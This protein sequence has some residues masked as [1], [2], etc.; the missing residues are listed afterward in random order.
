MSDAD[1][2]R[3]TPPTRAC[4]AASSRTLPPTLRLF[5]SRATAASATVRPYF[6][7]RSGSTAFH[8]RMCPPNELDLADARNGLEQ[9]ARSN[10]GPSEARSGAP[11]WPPRP[12]LR[13]RGPRACI[14]GRFRPWPE[15]GPMAGFQSLGERAPGLRSTAPGRAWRGEIDVDALEDDRDHRKPEL[16]N[17]A[18]PGSGGAGL[19]GLFR[20]ERSRIFRLPTE[21][22]P[23]PRTR[24]RPG[25]W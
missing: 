3:P 17:G 15:T 10:P 20:P 8:R 25:C 11:P 9:G 13:G 24:L 19:E 16:G 12:P 7:R 2:S 18:E 6:R 1:R 14:T 23:G 4:P 5:L 21:T 22:S